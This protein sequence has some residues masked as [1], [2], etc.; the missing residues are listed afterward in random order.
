M[1]FTVSTKEM[2]AAL[3]TAL[4]A[5]GRSSLQAANG[6]LITADAGKG[7]VEVTGT[8]IRTTVIRWIKDV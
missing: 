3:K 2:H 8:D 5:V 6:L 1:K 4:R 7:T